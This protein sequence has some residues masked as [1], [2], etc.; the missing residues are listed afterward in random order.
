MKI[1]FFVFLLTPFLVQSKKPSALCAALFQEIESKDAVFNAEYLDGILRAFENKVDFKKIQKIQKHFLESYRSLNSDDQ[2]LFFKTWFH[3][4]APALN[5]LLMNIKKTKHNTN[6]SS[7]LGYLNKLGNVILNHPQSKKLAQSLWAMGYIPE[8]ELYLLSNSISKGMNRSSLSAAETVR[9]KSTRLKLS[10]HVISKAKLR[11]IDL[12]DIQS[13]I[14]GGK[15]KVRQGKQ[16]GATNI[17]ADE[18]N[19]HLKFDDGV[20][21]AGYLS[22]HPS[23]KFYEFKL[24]TIYNR[25]ELKRLIDLSFNIL[26]RPTQTKDDEEHSINEE[27]AD[28]LFAVYHQFSEEVP[29]LKIIS[30]NLK[31]LMVNFQAT[32]PQVKKIFD[33]I[34]SKYKHL[35]GLQFEDL[36]I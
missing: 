34:K 11:D 30:K 19:L 7:Y 36:E 33:N 27:I 32:K 1:F 17:K 14:R 2:R 22:K 15:F 28:Y 20:I 5:K 12:E 3:S 8:P 21:A 31:K 18:L 10:K 9:Q 6:P 23:G 4:D 29:N 16:E 25:L 26:G 13:R 35:E 24:S